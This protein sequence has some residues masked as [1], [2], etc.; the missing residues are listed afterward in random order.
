MIVGQALIAAP[1]FLV[2]I[3]I[4]SLAIS[5]I[6]FLIYNAIIFSITKNESRKVNPYVWSVV[7]SIII[8]CYFVYMF[9]YG[10]ELHIN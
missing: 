2:F 3:L 7:V 1:F 10:D 6:G 8:V 4:V 5:L 9:Y